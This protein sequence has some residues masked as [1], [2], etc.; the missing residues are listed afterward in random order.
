MASSCKKGYYFCNSSQKCKRIPRGHKVQSDGELVREYVSDWR[1]D[2]QELAPSQ[3]GLS[4]LADRKKIQ[5]G[6]DNLPQFM[7]KTTTTT[8]NGKTSTSSTMVSREAEAK[9]QLSKVGKIRGVK[10]ELDSDGH[11]PNA[12]KFAAD[13]STQELKKV[14]P[15]SKISG[16]D[17]KRVKKYA[18]DGR[19]ER[20]INSANAGSW[21][22]RANIAADEV[23][24]G[25]QDARTKANKNKGKL[26]IGVTNNEELQGGVSVEPYTKDTKFLEVET[27][28]II[29]PK[30]LNAS[31]WRSELEVVN[32]GWKFVN[33]NKGR[34]D[35]GLPKGLKG[36]GIKDAG[37]DP[38]DVMK[39]MILGDR[40]KKTVDPKKNEVI[41]ASYETALNDLVVEILKYDIEDL[42]NIGFSYEEIAEYYDV[43]DEVVNLNEGVVGTGLNILKAVAPKIRTYVANRAVKDSKTVV[44]WA[45]KPGNWKALNKNID[46]VTLPVGKALKELPAR[47]Y[48]AG[49]N[50]RKAVDA[51]YNAGKALRGATTNALSSARKNLLPAAKGRLK[52]VTDVGTRFS[53][54]VDK[55]YSSLEKNVGQ[56]LI[57]RGRQDIAIRN[58]DKAKIN[59]TKEIFAKVKKLE[60]KGDVA[61]DVIDVTKTTKYKKPG[62]P[63]NWFPKK[64]QPQ[65]GIPKQSVDRTNKSLNPAGG[66]LTAIKDKGSALVSKVRNF[67]SKK[68]TKQLTGTKTPNKLS[69]TNIKGSLPSGSS[70]V[71]KQPY[72]AKREYT[73]RWMAYNK[74]ADA[75]LKADKASA[76]ARTSA[77]G[78]L[79]LT[80][81]GK[82]GQEIGKKLNNKK[83]DVSSQSQVSPPSLEQPKVEIPKVEKNTVVPK[84]KT[85]SNTEKKKVDP[86]KNPVVSKVVDTY[87]TGRKNTKSKDV[88]QWG[89]SKQYTA[90]DG[91]V[92][93]RS[94]V[95]TKAAFD[96]GPNIKK[97]EKIGVVG[98]GT[99]KRYDLEAKKRKNVKEGAAVLARVGSKLP[100]N[101]IIGAAMTGIGAS[102]MIRQSKKDD[103][104]ITPKGDIPADI[105]QEMDTDKKWKELSP[106]ENLG[107]KLQ[108]N[109]RSKRFKKALEGIGKPRS[110]TSSAD[111]SADAE[112][113]VRLN[114]VRDAERNKEFDD[115]VAKGGLKNLRKGVKIRKI[116]KG[117]KNES[118]SDWRSEI[119]IS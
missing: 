54:F 45:R 14:K 8:K 98:H 43:K 34:N 79:G 93:D 70:K 19:L 18:S 113:D 44:N 56:K 49:R 116:E 86:K 50:F 111:K 97:G 94:N 103:I 115:E 29:K 92:V 73:K 39:K 26:R 74:A 117:Q 58:L 68:G 72:S 106:N 108:K 48:A 80:A 107:P 3:Q 16:S 35:Y 42:H 17:L 110:K 88:D 4:T 64:S 2:L 11:V 63:W 101:K 32:E 25:T 12:G 84:N 75:T 36:G 85:I 33:P 61:G 22:F 96:L 59:K 55:A 118:F 38:V 28:D 81:G 5:K 40:A 47:T 89:R 102:G 1:S 95:F 60:K 78:L 77:A 20:D 69:G 109:E 90:K 76:I 91:T 62:D 46:K 100:W 37:S 9:R 114:Q 112:L 21:Q 10:V 87:H 57:N 105:K 82:V 65:K 51:T 119:K 15:N 13:I 30:A 6:F 53:N 41:S 27:V 7:P 99:R 104:D 23:N 52:N 24:K 83:V 71:T 66:A 67:F 31:D